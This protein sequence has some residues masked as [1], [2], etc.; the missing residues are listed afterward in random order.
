MFPQ[1]KQLKLIFQELVYGSEK[2]VEAELFFES[3]LKEYNRGNFDKSYE[4]YE[5]AANL[6]PTEYAY[7]QNMALAKIG[8][9]KYDEALK[10]L[11][12]T[13]DSLTIPKENGRIYILRGGVLALKG[14]NNLAC[15]D[16]IIAGQKK[17]SLAPQLLIDNCRAMATKFNPEF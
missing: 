13:I 15:R 12:Y 5:K 3:G 9:M 8:E 1:N 14:K 2:M 6:I 16:F 11:N 10:I 7:R 17:D 4:E